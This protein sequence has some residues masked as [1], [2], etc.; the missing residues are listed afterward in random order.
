ML[1][2]KAKKA[3]RDYGHQLVVA[4]LLG[5]YANQVV[6]YTQSGES[7]LIERTLEEIT[8]KRDIEVKLIDTIVGLHDDFISSE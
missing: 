4:N 1:E 8:L 6:L 7:V 2:P 5:N 3:L